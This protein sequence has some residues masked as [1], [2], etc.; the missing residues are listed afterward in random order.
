[1]RLLFFIFIHLSI[2]NSIYARVANDS[3]IHLVDPEEFYI[4]MNIH[5]YH[6]LID[7]RTRLEYRISRIPGAILAENS[8]VLYSLTDLLDRDTPL[9]LYCTI[10]A[11]SIPAAERLAEKGFKMIFIL[12]PGF[13]GWKSAGKEIDRRRLKKKQLRNPE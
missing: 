7:V 3:T 1:M 9:F 10:N 8:S 13:A 5:Y 4:Q 11:R 6:L 12:E 2:F